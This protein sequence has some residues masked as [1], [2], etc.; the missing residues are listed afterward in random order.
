M[1]STVP[2]FDVSRLSF[3]VEMCIGCHSIRSVNDI[4]FVYL[5][6]SLK[7]TLV[8]S[9]ILPSKIFQAH[10][11]FERDFSQEGGAMQSC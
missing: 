5:V 7:E 6:Q 10:A 4:S 11:D 8:N 9:T 2:P 3:D 1:I